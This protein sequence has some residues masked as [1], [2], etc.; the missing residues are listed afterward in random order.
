MAGSETRDAA[1]VRIFP[2]GVPLAVVLG[3]VALQHFWP[4]VPDASLDPAVRWVI[5]GAIIAGAILLL[6]L[7][8]IL[9]MRGTG[10]T[11]N[12]YTASTEIV[13]AGPFGYTRNPMYLQMVLVCIGFAV[14]L[15]NVW[16]LL[17]T[18]VCA[19]LL[20]Y[21]AILPEEAYLEAKFGET[22]LAYKRRVRRWI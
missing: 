6:G 13:T 15:W 17:L 5:G 1:R 21:F 19:L 18:P 2:P 9:I 14:G 20:H 4:I 7:R 11:E 3:G 12:P 16:I 10:Q 22:Y 8:A